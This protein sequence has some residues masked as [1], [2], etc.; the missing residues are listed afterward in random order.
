MGCR[1]ARGGAPSASSMRVIP[2]LQTSLRASYSPPERSSG[3]IQYGLPITV[4]RFD[5][6]LLRRLLTPRSASLHAPALLQSRF[7]A[8][9]SLWMI[10]LSCR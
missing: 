9:T 3:A 8:F 2:R 1:L 10:L 6:V 7:A 4:L 5:K